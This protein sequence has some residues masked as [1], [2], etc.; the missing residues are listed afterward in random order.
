MI[1]PWLHQPVL[2][3]VLVASSNKDNCCQSIIFYAFS[4]SLSLPVST[5][6]ALVQPG[7]RSRVENLEREKEIGLGS[8]SPRSY[9]SIMPLL[10][11][12]ARSA[13]PLQPNL[14]CMVG[15]LCRR[16]ETRRWRLCATHEGVLVW[17]LVKREGCQSR[18]EENGSGK[19]SERMP[20]TL[21]IHHRKLFHQPPRPG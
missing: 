5:S 17:L 14:G 8:Q 12:R 19:D 15:L 11:S 6:R 9:L 1:T 16:R 4:L 2:A 20:C 3:A 10:L 7:R 21:S 13:H 18:A